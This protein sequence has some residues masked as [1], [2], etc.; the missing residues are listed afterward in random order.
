MTLAKVINLKI[1]TKTQP[2][3][4]IMD[5]VPPFSAEDEE[6]IR[7]CGRI[8]CP[9]DLSNIRNNERGERMLLHARIAQVL[10]ERD[11]LRALL[12]GAK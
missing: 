2:T 9:L 5:L 1:E 6:A 12:K 11:T 7:E 10:A 3:K 8:P 4:P